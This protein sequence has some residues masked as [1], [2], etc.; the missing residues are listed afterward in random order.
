MQET[1]Y[2][3]KCGFLQVRSHIIVTWSGE[4][5]PFVAESAHVIILRYTSVGAV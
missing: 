3:R 2:M 4:T 5:C 1:G